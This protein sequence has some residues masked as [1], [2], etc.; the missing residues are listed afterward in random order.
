MVLPRKNRRKVLIIILL[1]IIPLLISGCWGRRETREMNLSTALGFDKIMVNGRPQYHITILSSKPQQAGGGATGSSGGINEPQKGSTGQV[2]Y[3]TGDTLWDAG[4]NWNLR[5]SRRLFIGQVLVV[6]IGEDTARQ[7]ITQIIDF[8]NRHQD[9]RERGWVIVCQGSAADF[10]NAQPEYEPMLSLEISGIMR[11]AWLRASKAKGVDLFNVSYDLLTPG[12]EAVIP[13]MTLFTPPE[14]SSPIKQQNREPTSA[15][16]T[17]GQQGSQPQKQT[18]SI[19]GSAVFKSDRMVG[20]LNEKENQG[21][22]FLSNQVKGGTIPIAIESSDKN[23]SIRLKGSKTRIKPVFSQDGV[24]LD[25]NIKAEGDLLEEDNDVFRISKTDFK[26][27]EELTRH[28]IERRCRLALQKSL[29]LESDIFGFGDK[30]HRS[31]PQQWQQIKDQWNDIFPTLQ[32]NIN[33]E[34]KLKQTGVLGDP[35]IVQ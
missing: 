14:P 15:A 8:L 4:R 16:Q 28:E 18:F 19:A 7:G 12:K 23:A 13:Y 35:L 17:S 33:V 30:I 24:T 29:E 20:L 34:F 1:V 6:V 27:V 26:K 10:L 9:M 21:Q 22:L 31:D 2:I 5:S 11:D 3:L 25:I 32:V